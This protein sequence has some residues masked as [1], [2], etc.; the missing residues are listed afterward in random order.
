MCFILRFVCVLFLHGVTVVIIIVG[1]VN[2]IMIVCR[3]KLLHVRPKHDTCTM[4]RSW[5]INGV[6]VLADCLAVFNK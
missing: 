6:G 3:L 4:L 2:A 1:F 5:Y